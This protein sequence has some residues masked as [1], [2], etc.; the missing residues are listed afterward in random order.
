MGMQMGGRPEQKPFAER[1][2]KSIAESLEDGRGELTD[3][4]VNQ[5]KDLTAS[6]L[7]TYERSHEKDKGGDA[8][9]Y[10]PNVEQPEGFN[11]LKE[12]ASKYGVSPW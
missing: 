2:Q 11:T 8:F 3:A 5:I 6:W 7:K 1:M 4:E 9:G 12:I 10:N